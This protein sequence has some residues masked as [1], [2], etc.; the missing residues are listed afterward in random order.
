MDVGSSGSRCGGADRHSNPP[1]VAWQLRRYEAGR[2]RSLRAADRSWAGYR[3]Y[4]RRRDDR[5][6]IPLC[7]GD[8][9]TQRRDIEKARKLAKEDDDGA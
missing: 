4:F 5:T 9:G 2:R 7:G 3:V 6:V 8:K 1:P